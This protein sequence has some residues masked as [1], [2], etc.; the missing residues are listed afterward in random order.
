MTVKEFKKTNWNREMPKVSVKKTKLSLS[1]SW[2]RFVNKKTSKQLAGSQYILIFP[3][4][5]PELIM[6]LVT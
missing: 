3:S 1:N 4:F 2:R 5:L 6:Q